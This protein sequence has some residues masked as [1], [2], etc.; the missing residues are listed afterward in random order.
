MKIVK[1]PRQAY[2]RLGWAY[3]VLMA[4]SQGLALAAAAALSLL[5]PEGL[6]ASGWL[7]WA[8]SYV[9]LYGVAAPVFALLI[10]RMFPKTPPPAGGTAMTAGLFARLFVMLMGA[11]YLLNYVSLALNW[12]I[13]GRLVNTLGT[14]T[15]AAGYWPSV[16]V[17]CVIA[18]IGEE[19]LFRKALWRAV[20]AYGERAYALVGGLVFALFHGNL[21]QLLY[22]FLAGAVLCLLYVRTG[23][24]VWCVAL[25][26][27]INAMGIAVGPLA[28]RGGAAA[29][30]IGAAVLALMA[31]SL[32]L[33]GRAVR[34]ARRRPAAP[35]TPAH[36]LCTAL[37]APGMAVYALACL[38]LVAY[39]SLA[40]A[41]G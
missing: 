4:L 28:E 21:S 27:A 5:W 13:S 11:T 9:P 12:L 36:P 30:F 17:G 35:G 20:G 24:L 33:M 26:M 18:P 6:A 23:R 19:L 10:T 7:L 34:R 37:C 31:A 16:A 8:V 40:P 39:A 1:T 41:L 2:S 15:Q 3:L 38:A 32:V 25:H 14:V 29:A 22:A